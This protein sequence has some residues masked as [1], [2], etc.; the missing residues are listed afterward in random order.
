MSFAYFLFSV[1]VS[2]SWTLLPTLKPHEIKRSKVLLTACGCVNLATVRRKL[3][4]KLQKRK[5]KLR[6]QL[7]V[8][9]HATCE[10]TKK[11]KN[12]SLHHKL[13]LFIHSLCKPI[14]LLLKSALGKLDKG[15]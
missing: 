7:N 15:Y 10:V 14:S 8:I 12:I 9:A 4:I 3:P 2:T 5:K 11:L 13:E 1:F 6:E